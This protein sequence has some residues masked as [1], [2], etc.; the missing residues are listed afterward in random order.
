MDE[1]KPIGSLLRFKKAHASNGS[2]EGDQNS[3]ITSGNE[4]R[5]DQPHPLLIDIV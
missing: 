4:V 5:E 3:E 2:S 1:K